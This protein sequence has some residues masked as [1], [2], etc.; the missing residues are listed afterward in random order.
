MMVSTFTSRLN[1]SLT[2]MSLPPGVLQQVRA[3]EIKLAGLPIPAGLNAAAETALKESIATAFV[4]AFRVVIIVC[5]GLSIA[6]TA[7]ADRMIPRAAAEDGASAQAG[8]PLT[9]SEPP[10]A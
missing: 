2:G 6:A 3:N 5:A 10:A 8:F 7:V 4:F 9:D 1:R